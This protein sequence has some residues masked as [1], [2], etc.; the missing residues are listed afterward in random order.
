MAASRKQGDLF[1]LSGPGKRKSSFLFRVISWTNLNQF[2]LQRNAIRF[3]FL[4]ESW[5]I[6][7]ELLT[8]ITDLGNLG[9]SWAPHG[10]HIFSNF[11]KLHS[12]LGR[13]D[14]ML[15][16]QLQC[17]LPPS[18]PGPHDELILLQDTFRTSPLLWSLRWDRI[19]PSALYL[20]INMVVVLEAQALKP[21]HPTS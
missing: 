8:G 5:T 9:Q 17:P 12:C 20:D 1:P 13:L 11:S 7:L 15:G 19:V 21:V 4:S 6:A 14:W 18:S 2:L 3:E 10:A 16:N